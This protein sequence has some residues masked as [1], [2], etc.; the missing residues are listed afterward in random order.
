MVV[1]SDEK[2]VT[3]R[4]SKWRNNRYHWCC[5]MEHVSKMQINAKEYAKQ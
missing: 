2:A 5:N 3:L 4:I 1:R